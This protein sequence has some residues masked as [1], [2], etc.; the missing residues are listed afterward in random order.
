MIGIVFGT[1]P[2]WIKIRPIL[3]EFNKHN[4]Q[5]R[6]Y[7]VCQ[8]DSKMLPKDA[9]WNTEI[10]IDQSS[11]PNENRL[12][13]IIKSI[14]SS[15][16]MIGNSIKNIDAFLVQGDT[17]TAYA[18]ALNA[19][20][21][22]IP[23]IHVE[24][25]LRTY[26]LTSPYPEEGYRQMISVLADIQ[27]CPT[28]ES[29]MNLQ[30]ENITDSVYVVGNTA[31]DNIKNFNLKPTHNKEVLCTFHRRESD[32]KKWFEELN[33]T[34]QVLKANGYTV[35]LPLHESPSVKVHKK[36]LK[37]VN[38]VDPIDYDSFIKRLAE[39]AFVITDS[40]GIQEEASFLDKQILV[41]R[42]TTE[43]P[44]ILGLWSKLVTPETLHHEAIQ[45]MVGQEY[46]KSVPYVCPYGD[47]T[48]STK[49]ALILKSLGY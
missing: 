2:E 4:I 46:K 40:G 5:H 10:G 43:R 48:A 21:H 1:R 20:N 17:A 39:C 30:S 27:F 22:Q 42:D 8:H 35:T 44:E 13:S 24:A 3:K 14:L 25:G 19:Y 15:N 29:L 7:R 47:G 49:I 18:A 28:V 16:L 26:D 11:T 45:L 23:I 38:V 6:V 9:Y 32:I 12:N 34:A 37:D 31:L 36:I 41:C 33:K